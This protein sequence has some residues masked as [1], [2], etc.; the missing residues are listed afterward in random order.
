M[1]I[2]QKTPLYNIF[3]EFDFRPRPLVTRLGGRDVSDGSAVT[4]LRR[5]ALILRGELG[6]TSMLAS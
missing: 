2:D 4:R 1:Y 3:R 6:D 5:A